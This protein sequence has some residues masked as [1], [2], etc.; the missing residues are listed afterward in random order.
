MRHLA[1][2][3]GCD[4]VIVALPTSYCKHLRMIRI[5]TVYVTSA[6]IVPI[7]IIALCV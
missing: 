5:F 2:C 1:V 6:W 3:D 7:G 4:K